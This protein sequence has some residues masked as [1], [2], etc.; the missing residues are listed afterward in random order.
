MRT[1]KAFSPA[2]ISSFFQICDSEPDGTP[3]TDPER[4]GSRGGGFALKRGV[5]TEVEVEESE[6]KK[7]EVF[8]NGRSAP[9]AETTRRVIEMLLKKT[10]CHYRVKVSHKVDVPVGAGFGTSAAGAL[11]TVM[12]LSRA[13]GTSLTFSQIGR[14]AHI[15]EVECRTGLGTV[16]G[17]LYG[18]CVLVKKPGVPD[19]GSI[20]RIP[21]PP[22]YYIVAGVFQPR[23]TREFLEKADREIIN[24]VG[25]ETLI[26][27]LEEPS[28]ENFMRRSREFAEKTGLVTERVVRLMDASQDAG[29][30]GAA[31]NMLG[32][33]VHA[34]VPRDRLEPVLEAFGKFLPDERIIVSEIENQGVRLVG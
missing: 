24:R 1:S 17:L 27:I 23:M 34:L 22:G 2:G 30:L 33:A 26:R 11:G 13:L 32:E 7:V 5:L 10:D 3:I 16:S 12:A 8:I 9:E 6:E 18:G 19:S 25:A 20:D 4:I 29:A 21:V 14:L 15:A 28:L 31:Q